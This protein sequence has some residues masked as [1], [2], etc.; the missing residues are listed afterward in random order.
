LDPSSIGIDDKHVAKAFATKEN[1]YEYYD[2]ANYPEPERNNDIHCKDSGPSDDK[3]DDEEKRED[4]ARLLEDHKE[5]G[6][7]VWAG[8]TSHMLVTACLSRHVDHRMLITACTVLH[9]L[10]CQ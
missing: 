4:R 5:K 3:D 7:P 1:I 6:V 2:P 8:P 10:T 9:I